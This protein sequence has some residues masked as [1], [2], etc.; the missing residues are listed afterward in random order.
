MGKRLA[1]LGPDPY[2]PPQVRSSYDTR[3]TNGGRTGES[4]R[5]A[6]QW[7]AFWF[8]HKAESSTFHRVSRHLAIHLA[9]AYGISDLVS[10]RISADRYDR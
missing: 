3:N 4:V 2:P 6:G 1:F 9:P 10:V 7:Y 5:L 8:P